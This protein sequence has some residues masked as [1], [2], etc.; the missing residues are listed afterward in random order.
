MIAP[1]RR[2]NRIMAGAREQA[3]L[4]GWP[5][6]IADRVLR[7]LGIQEVRL[8]V[9]GLKRR[10]AY[11]VGTADI[12]EFAQSLGRGRTPLALAFRPEFI[13][14]AGA[15]VGYTALRFEMEFPGA[16]IVALEPEPNNAAQ[17][18]K[19]CAGYPN[20]AL[21]QKALWEKS[22]RLKVMQ[23]EVAVNSFQIGEHPNG[24]IEGVSVEELMQRRRL[25]RI[26]LFKI[27]IEGTEKRLFS[28]PNAAQ[29]IKSVR[30]FLIETHD[31]IEEGCEAAIQRALADDF[32]FAGHI[33]EYV[34]YVSRRDSPAPS[35]PTVA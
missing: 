29:W 4:V 19:N 6:A 24:D 9:R 7:R 10:V 13:V 3:A 33:N 23:T 30:I 15:N 18:R 12:Y 22:A 11:R 21:E 28:H 35:K 26:D 32:Q 20:I 5:W 16:T 8:S 31:R 17:F 27:D 1:L 34:V 14:D 2:I 25:P